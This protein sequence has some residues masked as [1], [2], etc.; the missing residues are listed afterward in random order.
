MLFDLHNFTV[1]QTSKAV[2]KWLNN[3]NE[4]NLMYSLAF[5]Y[6][7]N[8]NMGS[9]DFR[10]QVTYKGRLQESKIQ[11]EFRIEGTVSELQSVTKLCS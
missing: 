1:S 11:A 9:E 2:N 5:L 6:M 4:T 3:L 8:I 7:Y 10:S